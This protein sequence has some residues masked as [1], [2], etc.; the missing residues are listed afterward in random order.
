MVRKLA[1]SFPL[2]ETEQQALLDMP[3]SVRNLPRGQV[4]L[5]AGAFNPDIRVLVSG[6]ACSYT[7]SVHGRRIL[8]A[9]HTDGDILNL[10]AAFTAKANDGARLLTPGRVASV[11]GRIFLA[12]ALEAPRLGVAFWRE[13]SAGETVAQARVSDI[14]R[15]ACARLVR[16][17][18]EPAWR[19]EATGPPTRYQVNV[20]MTVAEIA[21][22]IALS[23]TH[24]S[25]LFSDLAALGLARRRG[26]RIE[27]IKWER[28]AQIGDCAGYCLPGQ[29]RALDD[30]VLRDAPWRA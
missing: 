2:G 21:E 11:P 1:T 18:L 24:V 26:H 4:V 12:L 8:T 14:G 13:A 5:Q 6:V 23:P 22:A 29:A 7:P 15:D 16:L 10:K 17:L 25:R 30:A 19:A 28:L 20:P 9:V 3:C 27:I